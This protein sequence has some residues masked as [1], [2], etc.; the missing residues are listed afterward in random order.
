MKP[1]FSLW[2]EP[3]ITVEGEDGTLTE[4][5]MA[6]TLR[7]A[8]GLHA[9]HDPSPLVVVGIHR[10][11]TAVLQDIFTPQTE[12]DLAALWDRECFPEDSIRA[13]GERYAHRFDLFSEHAPFLQSADIPLAPDKKSWDIALLFQELPTGT[14]VTHYQHGL[15]SD[16]VFCPTCAARGLV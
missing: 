11:L 2:T 15:S 8:A 4:M 3:W 5:S 10:L 13:F 12:E 16:H 14:F 1:S 7:D 6:Q 9:I